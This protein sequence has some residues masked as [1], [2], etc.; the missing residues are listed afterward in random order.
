MTLVLDVVSNVD[1][2]KIEA[3]VQKIR[4]NLAKIPD[5]VKINIQ[6][7]IDQNATQQ[8]QNLQR[9]IERAVN[10]NGASSSV[11]GIANNVKAVS[12]SIS[13]MGSSSSHALRDQIDALTGVSTVTKS[14]KDSA[15]AMRMAWAMAAQEAKA[16][17]DAEKVLAESG[18]Q[19]AEAASKTTYALPDRRTYRSKQGS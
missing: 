10:A 9:D 14:A 5:K 12:Q 1:Y 8:I 2:S 7:G 13:S 4:D 16:T 18:A 11:K 3:E 19:Q 6:V 15:D 17:S